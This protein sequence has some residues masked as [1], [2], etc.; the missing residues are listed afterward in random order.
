MRE[1][2][3]TYEFTGK[4]IIGNEFE[5]DNVRCIYTDDYYSNKLMKGKFFIND[6]S[7]DNINNIRNLINDFI[8]SDKS[9]RIIKGKIYGFNSKTE[10]NLRNDLFHF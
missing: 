4:L 3:T 6:L 1:F 9:G 10:Y 2:I 7:A 5:G 8:F